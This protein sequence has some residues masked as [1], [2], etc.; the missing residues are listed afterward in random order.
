MKTSDSLLDTLGFNATFLMVIFNT[1]VLWKQRVYFYAYIVFFIINMG[2]NHVLKITIKQPR[3]NDYKLHDDT[4]IYTHSSHVYGMPSAHSQSIFFSITYLWLVLNSTR[5]LILGL[6]LSALTVYQRWKY[7]KH[8]VEQLITGALIGSG[9][10]Y[11][12]YYTVTKN[13]Q[14]LSKH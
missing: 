13:M 12:A 2:I 5:Y 4:G 7:K 10:A 11:F 1:I 9:F 14:Y 3:P 6:F 8:S